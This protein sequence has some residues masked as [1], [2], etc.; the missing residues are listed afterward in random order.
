M[1][2]AR[3]GIPG[4][5][6]DSVFG[7]AC[8]GRDSG[9]AGGGVFRDTLRLYGVLRGVYWHEVYAG[10][11][12]PDYLDS[13]AV[14]GKHVFRRV[15]GVYKLV[16]LIDEQ[17]D[18]SGRFRY[19]FQFHVDVFGQGAEFGEGLKAEVYGMVFVVVCFGGVF[20]CAADV[21]VYG[22]MIR[23]ENRLANDRE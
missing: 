7:V 18:I 1:G 6:F 2:I 14:D 16:F 8:G 3:A 13:M 10:V 12:C 20:E 23:A 4:V 21:G 17:V 19:A 22:E 5:D 15:L 9:D 11:Y